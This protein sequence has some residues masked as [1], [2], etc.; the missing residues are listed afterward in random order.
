MWNMSYQPS[1]PPGSS[2][3]LE[4]AHRPYADL[5][6]EIEAVDAQ[7]RGRG[8]RPS[9]PILGSGGQQPLDATTPDPWHQGSARGV[10]QARGPMTAH[11]FEYHTGFWGGFLSSLW[12]ILVPVVAGMGMTFLLIVVMGLGVEENLISDYGLN[13]GLDRWLR[14]T[15]G[16]VFFGGALIGLGATVIDLLRTHVQVRALVRAARRGAPRSRVPAPTQFDYVTRSPGIPLAWFLG[17]LGVMTGLVAIIAFFMA[18]FD[19][20]RDS[21]S[22]WAFVAMTATTAILGGLIWI[23][24]RVIRPRIARDQRVITDH[25]DVPHQEAALR[26]AAPAP[27]AQQLQA[28]DK[29]RRLPRILTTVG[30]VFL[31][32]GVVLV[33][34]MLMVRKPEGRQGPTAYYEPHIEARIQVVTAA[35]VVLVALGAAALTAAWLTSLLGDLRDRRDL[36]AAFDDPS[37]T[38]V[39]PVRVN[40]HIHPSSSVGASQL[41]ALGAAILSLTL[42]AQYMARQGQIPF[43]D[44]E[45]PLWWATAVGVILTVGAWISAWYHQ[46][47]GRNWRNALLARWPQRPVQ[48]PVDSG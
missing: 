20:F 12:S 15:V 13:R 45:Q 40:H 41:S 5:I 31:V 39:D 19:G 48:P 3:E 25:W 36:R 2:P 6:A 38:S 21:I 8:H 23:I 32:P 1:P 9:T 29:A 28:G 30:S 14:A 33:M 10:A 24:L 47:H 7:A 27:S 26:M 18:L 22:N 34:L 4:R 17:L 46:E 35:F 37:V 11:W 43:T 44:W 42:T 16:W